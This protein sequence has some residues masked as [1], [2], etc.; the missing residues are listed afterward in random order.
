MDSLSLFFFQQEIGDSTTIR[1]ISIFPL[2]DELGAAEVVFGESQ[3][4]REGRVYRPRVVTGVLTTNAL[5]QVAGVFRMNRISDNRVP[6]LS[7]LRR[8]DRVK[9]KRYL[10]FPLERFG[11]SQSGRVVSEEEERG[12]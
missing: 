2:G 9:E 12:L 3:Q 1:R 8:S 7:F 6:T 4:L 5:A 10:S 11:R